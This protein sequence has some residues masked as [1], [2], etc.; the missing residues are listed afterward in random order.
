MVSEGMMHAYKG[1]KQPKAIPSYDICETQHSNCTDAVVP[2]TC[3]QRNTNQNNLEIPP[4][5]NQNC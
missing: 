4:C 1:G 5:S 2:C 3:Y